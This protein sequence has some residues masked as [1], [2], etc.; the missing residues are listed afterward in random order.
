MAVKARRGG[1]QY[2]VRDVPARVDEALRSKARERRVSLNDVLR[3]A[4]VREAGVDPDE[5]VVHDDLDDLAGRWDEDP[6]FDEAIEAQDR[7]D[8]SLWK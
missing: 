3:A 5:G 1:V 4:L 8:E 2:T 7:V 6:A